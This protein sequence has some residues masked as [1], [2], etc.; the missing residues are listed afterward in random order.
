MRDAA[1]AAGLLFV[2]EG[3]PC[4]TVRPVVWTVDD[5][6]AY[7]SSTLLA[8]VRLSWQCLLRMGGHVR[9]AKGRAWRRGPTAKVQVQRQPW[10]NTRIKRRLARAMETVPRR[11]PAWPPPLAFGCARPR[12]E[13]GS[14]YLKGQ[15]NLDHWSSSASKWQSARHQISRASKRGG[16]ITPGSSPHDESQ[17]C[18]QLKRAS[19]S[20][21]MSSM[22]LWFVGLV[23]SPIS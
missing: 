17:G 11:T 22:I 14:Q 5:A 15:V 12:A 21:R 23:L 1:A 9:D 4:H 2:D 3:L 8:A 7:A 13:G 19:G 6:Q 18:P 10:A 16:P 20:S